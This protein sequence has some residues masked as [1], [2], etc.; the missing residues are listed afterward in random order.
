MKEYFQSIYSFEEYHFLYVLFLKLVYFV[1]NSFSVVLILSE[2]T[3]I[4]I[5]VPFF[6]D[7]I[8]APVFSSLFWKILL[9]LTNFILLLLV[10]KKVILYFL[11]YVHSSLIFIYLIFRLTLFLPLIFHVWLI[12]LRELCLCQMRIFCFSFILLIVDIS[13][14]NFDQ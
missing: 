5:S 14:S 2:R 6:A 13:T 1:D 3:E 12:L 9:Y 10:S 11:L 8:R 4:Q 7:F